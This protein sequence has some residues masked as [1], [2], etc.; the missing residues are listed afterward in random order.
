MG[1]EAN[2]RW[3]ALTAS[4]GRPSWLVLEDPLLSLSEELGSVGK[5]EG[6]KLASSSCGWSSGVVSARHGWLL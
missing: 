2:G 6:S 1:E 4:S 5:D 3:V